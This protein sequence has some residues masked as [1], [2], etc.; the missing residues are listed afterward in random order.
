MILATGEKENQHRK[1][2]KK[3][4][5]NKEKL[6][7]SVVELSIRCNPFDLVVVRAFTG[8]IALAP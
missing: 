5:H 1:E 8:V 3:E 2:H 7:E 6:Q 4:E